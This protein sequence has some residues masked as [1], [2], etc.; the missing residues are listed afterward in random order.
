VPLA[1]SLGLPDEIVHRQPFPGPGL[2]VRIIG[3][4]THEKLEMLRLADAIVREEIS[5]SGTATARCGSTSP[6]SP[7]S[8][9]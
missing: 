5:A 6:C 8:A 4:I 9:R 1:P 7:T 2:A 3:D